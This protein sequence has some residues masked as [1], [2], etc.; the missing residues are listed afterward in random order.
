MQRSKKTNATYQSM[1]DGELMYEFA[2]YRFNK[3]KTRATFRCAGCRSAISDGRAPEFKIY[4]LKGAVDFETKK[5]IFDENPDEHPHCCERRNPHFVKGKQIKRKVRNEIKGTG[6]VG[7]Q[8]L[9]KLNQKVK[10]CEENG[11]HDG[12][13]SRIGLTETVRRI[14]KGAAK[15]TFVQNCMPA[16]IDEELQKS[17]FSNA[18][19]K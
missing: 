8:C 16:D 4:Y 7:S 11:D 6:I 13:M 1:I 10:E 9:T 15:P 17:S 18:S 12:V 19:N 3:K 14:L 5:V 2:I